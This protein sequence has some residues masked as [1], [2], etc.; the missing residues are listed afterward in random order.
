[1][2][3]KL[4]TLQKLSANPAT[5][6]SPNHALR[7]VT[8]SVTN[9]C[10]LSRGAQCSIYEVTSNQPINGIGDGNTDYDWDI[11]GALTV[12][13]RAERSGVIDED[14]IYTMRLWCIEPD[15]QR[16]YQ[17]VSVQVARTK[18]RVRL[19]LSIWPR[20]NMDSSHLAN[21]AG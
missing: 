6:W 8:I 3:N 17:E 20:L 1:M 21:Q 14:R 9:A 18:L 19:T 13:L 16:S 15:G 2:D 5:L 12:D 7:S 4:P 10:E 11:T